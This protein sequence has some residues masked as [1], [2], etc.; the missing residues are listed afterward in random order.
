VPEA[1][2][3]ALNAGI[4]VELQERGIAVPS[5]TWV[6]GRLA[7]RVNVMN[8]RTTSADLAQTIAAVERAAL[9]RSA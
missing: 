6:D 3:D 2:L 5:T 8:H 9:E 4:A 7:L 1:D